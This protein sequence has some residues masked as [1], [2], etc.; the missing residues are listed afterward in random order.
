MPANKS[1]FSTLSALL[2][3]LLLATPVSS[4]AV[5]PD[6]VLS[7]E[8]PNIVKTHSR[9]VM[10]RSCFQ[11]YCTEAGHCETQRSSCTPIPQSWESSSEFP[12][13]LETEHFIQPEVG[14]SG[15]SI[16]S[17]EQMPVGPYLRDETKGRKVPTQKEDL[18]KYLFE[19]Y[20]QS[21]DGNALGA[22]EKKLYQDYKQHREAEQSHSEQMMNHPAQ[23]HTCVEKQCI[24]I[25]GH[26]I[27]CRVARIPCRGS[28]APATHPVAPL[29]RKLHSLLSQHKGHP[30]IHVVRITPR[31]ARML[32]RSLE[33]HD[34]HPMQKTRQEVPQVSAADKKMLQE[35][36][37]L[38]KEFPK[39]VHI[40]QTPQS[41]RVEVSSAKAGG[42]DLLQKLEAEMNTAMA[43]T[44]GA[45]KKQADP[46]QRFIQE[47]PPIVKMD[48]E[49]VGPL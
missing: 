34:S 47:A 20:A 23:Q 8:Q 14:G 7:E 2:L 25:Q 24:N 28:R 4:T 40:Q 5:H 15:P 12:R 44:M 39:N 31:V 42:A 46:V 48:A 9:I 45:A 16:D 35:A 38:Q 6:A 18:E 30:I 43:G 27:G 11:K 36:E 29:A 32:E 49:E 19:K 13:F 22:L 41:F 33:Q 21:H 17:F 3:S 10:E 26:H 1:V 37:E